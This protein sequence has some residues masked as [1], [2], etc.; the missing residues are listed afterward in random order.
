MK[1]ILNRGYNNSLSKTI[2]SKNGQDT[3]VR[4]SNEDVYEFDAKDGDHV[5]IKLRF[6]DYFSATI[7]SFTYD[8]KHNIIYLK[9]SKVYHIWDLSTCMILPYLCL[10]LLALKTSI[11]TVSYDYFCAGIIAITALSLVCLKVINHIPS[12]RKKIFNHCFV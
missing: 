10:F 4:H 11:T 5:S 8:N 1:I 7:Y 3:T 2:I 12:I 6:I 9:P